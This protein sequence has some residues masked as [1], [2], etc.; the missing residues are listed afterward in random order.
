MSIQSDEL[1]TGTRS[2]FETAR[3]MAEWGT[4]TRESMDTYTLT[5]RKRVGIHRSSAQEVSEWYTEGQGM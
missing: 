1:D 2:M 4:D 5:L 3:K